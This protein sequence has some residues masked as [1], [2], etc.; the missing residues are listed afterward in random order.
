LTL[1]D[2]F[3]HLL[4]INVI[5]LNTFIRIWIELSHFDARLAEVLVESFVFTLIQVLKLF[6]GTILLN[7][8]HGDIECLASD[9]GGLLTDSLEF[10]VFDLLV[11]NI[12]NWFLDPNER[13]LQ[14]I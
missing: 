9:S 8:D 10:N 5:E 13:A 14:R 11:L 1:A 4:V 7:F 12:Q 3:V 6:H 2:L